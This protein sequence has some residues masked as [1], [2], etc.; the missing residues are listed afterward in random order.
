MENVM[1]ALGIIAGTATSAP[2]QAARALTANTTKA[3]PATSPELP[4]DA[5]EVHT[6]TQQ[7][8]YD[9]ELQKDLDASTH[10]ALNLFDRNGDKKIDA[11]DVLCQCAPDGAPVKSAAAAARYQKSAAGW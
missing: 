3:Q 2:H 4:T 8:T 6:G 1:D 5:V 10:L 7:Y 9:K 11:R